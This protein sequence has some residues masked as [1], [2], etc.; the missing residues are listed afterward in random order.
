MELLMPTR[1][2]VLL[3]ALPPSALETRFGALH[4]PPSAEERQRHRQWEVEAIGPGV[5]DLVLLPGTRVL[6][7]PRCGQTLA[8]GDE[9]LLMVGEEDVIAWVDDA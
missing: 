5:Q 4:L 2:L 8:R 9:T 7:R 6:V 3:R 1:D